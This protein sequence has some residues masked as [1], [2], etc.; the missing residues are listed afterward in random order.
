MPLSPSMK[1]VGQLRKNRPPAL[2][3][4]A[5]MTITNHHGHRDINLVRLPG[6]AYCISVHY[7]DSHAKGQ[8]EQKRGGFGHIA[9]APSRGESAMI[10]VGIPVIQPAST[11]SVA[12][13][14]DI[15]HYA[16]YHMGGEGQEPAASL[17]FQTD[18][19]GIDAT[20]VCCG[21]S[22]WLTP[23]QVIGTGVSYD[24]ILVPALLDDIEKSLEANGAFLP[25]LRE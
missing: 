11:I 13:P 17:T 9:P 16:A 1:G 14:R 24:V 5:T 23:Q 4:P 6:L 22:V 18:F 20:P 19:V 15:L 12:A 25:W 2:D 10:R 8:C 7:S 21:D 3:V